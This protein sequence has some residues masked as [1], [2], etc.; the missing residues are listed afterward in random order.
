[1]KV[2]FICYANFCRSPVA[3][4]LFQNYSKENINSSSAG[5]IN[6]GKYEMDPR[7]KDYLLNHGIDEVSHTTQKIDKQMMG[8]AERVY[9][10]D[11]KVLMELQN[12]FPNYMHKVKVLNFK[13][14]SIKTNDPYR[15]KEINQYNECLENIH[16]IIKSLVADVN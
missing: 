14:P 3:E 5:I 1:M 11:L 13:D 10:L 12:K 6:L 16:K 4:K 7:S 9:A 2:I 8:S 15:F